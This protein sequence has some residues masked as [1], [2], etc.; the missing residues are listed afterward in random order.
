[1]DQNKQLLLSLSIVGITAA[2][3]YFV[4]RN[5]SK[6]ILVA[7]NPERKQ[8]FKLIEKEVINHD[9]RRFRFALQ[10]P[11]HVLGLPIG[12]HMYL[13]ARI[14]DKLVVRPYTPVTSDDEIGYF[15]LVIKVYFKNSHP[16]FPEGGK[17]TQYL[18]S[19]KIGETIDVRGPSGYL[20]YVGLGTFKIEELKKPIRLMKCK[21]LGLIAGGTGITPMLQIIRAILKN[22]KDNT[23]IYLLFANQTEEDILLRKELEQIVKSHKNQFSLWYTLDRPGNGWNYSTGFI[24]EQMIS[25]HLPKCSEESVV[26]MCGPPPM[27]NYACIPNLVKLGYDESQYFSF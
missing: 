16:K 11:E 25:E 10:S 12:K 21:N 8:P 19:M 23:K 2:I 27:I 4:W 6:R 24:N 5:K 1:M 3:F 15:D 9:T 17:M 13:S 14:D 7:L 26:L 18:E 20:S 22:P